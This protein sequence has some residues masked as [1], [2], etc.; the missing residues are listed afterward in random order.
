MVMWLR[1]GKAMEGLAVSISEVSAKSTDSREAA[2]ASNKR[3]MLL[4]SDWTICCAS[5]EARCIW[6]L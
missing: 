2:I 1:H 3:L 5:K 6:C 4:G